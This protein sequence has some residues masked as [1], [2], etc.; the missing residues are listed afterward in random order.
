MKA[1]AGGLLPDVPMCGATVGL[2]ERRRSTSASQNSAGRQ[3]GE[4]AQPSGRVASCGWA[5]R[6]AAG[7]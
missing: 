4:C 7:A 2:V 5:R 3:G 6:P 1:G